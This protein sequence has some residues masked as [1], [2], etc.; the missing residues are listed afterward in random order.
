MR[1][2][3]DGHETERLQFRLVTLGDRDQWLTFFE[4][5][6]SFQ[7]WDMQMDTP[8]V[9]CRKWYDKQLGRYKNDLGGMNALVEK[10]T[11]KLVGHCGLL[12]QTVDGAPELE[13]GYSLLGPFRGKG[14]ATEA[15]HACRDCAFRNAFADSLISI[16]SLANQPSANVARKNGMNLDKQ[17]FYNGNAVNIFRIRKSDW[18]LTH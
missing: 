8:E 7:Y 10:S 16:V 12:V 9:E 18:L 13:I 3:L 14:F 5:P 1:Y 15:A 6:N 17:T 4:D 11:G 2:L